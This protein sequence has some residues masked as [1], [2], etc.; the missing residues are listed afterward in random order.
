MADEETP[1]EPGVTRKASPRPV[2]LVDFG[3]TEMIEAESEV[4][5]QKQERK[6]LRKIAGRRKWAGVK[7]PT[8]ANQMREPSWLGFGLEMMGLMLS[9]EEEEALD[10]S[11]KEALRTATAMNVHFHTG[12]V[13]LTVEQEAMLDAHFKGVALSSWVGFGLECV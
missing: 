11:S 10:E 9:E 1:L 3:L 7:A 5:P 6:P 12:G 4:A 8:S 2:T 13:G